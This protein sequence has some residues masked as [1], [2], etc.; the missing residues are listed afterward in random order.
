MSVRP[1]S[2]VV[3]R[4]AVGHE[5]LVCEVLEGNGLIQIISSGF[6]QSWRAVLWVSLRMLRVRPQP[7]LRHVVVFQGGQSSN[8]L[9]NPNGDCAR[10]C[11]FSGSGLSESLQQCAV[12]S[13]GRVL[14]G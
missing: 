14:A 3:A 5:D 10:Q 4:L 13:L 8:A 7:Q 9:P 12:I 1:F 2:C 11:H 6:E